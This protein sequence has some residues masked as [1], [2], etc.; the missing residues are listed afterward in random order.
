MN[1][2]L[3]GSLLGSAR[4]NYSIKMADGT[5]DQSIKLGKAYG[6]NSKTVRGD[7][8]FDD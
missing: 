7:D 5:A 8:D 1:S 4:G 6:G 3:N 2:K